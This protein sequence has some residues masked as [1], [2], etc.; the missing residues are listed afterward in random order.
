MKK[1]RVGIVGFTGCAGCQLSILDL[2]D[3]L[4]EILKHVDIV[5]FRMAMT[6]N[7]TGPYDIL[8]VEGSIVNEAQEEK[9][10]KLRSKAK[11]LVAMGA[12][13][14]FGGPQAIRNYHRD[15]PIMEAAYGKDANKINVFKVKPINKVVPVDFYLLE[16]PVNKYDFLDFVKLAL[17]GGHPKLPNIPVCQECKSKENRC[18][19]L[20]DNVICMG[21]VIQAG[22]GALCPSHGLPCDG[23]RGSTLQPAYQQQVDLMIEKG[24]T[25]EEITRYLLKFCGED[26]EVKNYLLKIWSNQDKSIVYGENE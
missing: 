17:I 1:P 25:T 5:D 16:C 8:F 13:A 7:K 19:F 18:I 23:C 11:L 9:I 10:K 4:L 22:C 15:K 14:C 12:C 20:E 21:P 2:E 24:A 3:E 6:G 26:P